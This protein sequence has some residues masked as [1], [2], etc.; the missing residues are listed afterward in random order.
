MA[1]RRDSFLVRGMNI[2]RT[3]ITKKL[4]RDAAVAYKEATD[5]FY[6]EFHKHKITQ[7]LKS[8]SSPSAIL[9]TL[10]NWKRDGTLFGFMGFNSGYDP[11]NDLENFLKGEQG[12]RWELERNI[13]KNTRGILGNLRSPTPKEMEAANLKLQ[14][15]GDGRAWPEVIEDDGIENLSYF[16]AKNDYGRS[17]EGFQAKHELNKGAKLDAIPYLSPILK[18]AEKK[19]DVRLR[20]LARTRSRTK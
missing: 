13:I 4:E 5:Y 19:F 7:E 14:G 16:F 2:I 17:E 15:W 6:K 20:Q 18:K 11:I 1:K 3:R 9:N 8:H 12:F 10:G